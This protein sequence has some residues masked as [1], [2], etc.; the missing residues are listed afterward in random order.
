[1]RITGLPQCLHFTAITLLVA[2]GPGRELLILREPRL[3]VYSVVGAQVQPLE[4]HEHVKVEL[5]VCQV[6]EARLRVDGLT[7]AEPSL[8]PT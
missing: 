1:M 7:R 5:S 3:N 8:V 4:L 2:T 6:V